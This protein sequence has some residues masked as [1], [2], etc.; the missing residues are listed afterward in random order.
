[1]LNRNGHKRT[2]CVGRAGDKVANRILSMGNQPNSGWGEFSV[3]PK[4]GADGAAPGTCLPPLLL[5]WG[6]PRGSPS[7][8]RRHTEHLQMRSPAPDVLTQRGATW[9]DTGS[10][11][12]SPQSVGP[13]L[14][15]GVT[16]PCPRLSWEERSGETARLRPAQRREKNK[17]ASSKFSLCA[18]SPSPS[19]QQV[20][21]FSWRDSAPQWG[22][23][24]SNPRRLAVCAGSLG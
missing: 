10:L 6:G 5:D 24:A 19:L 21:A 12:G 14:R 1:M 16:H 4:Q 18:R 3:F 13:C 2:R 9:R 8:S 23:R 20:G 17:P 7:G 15:S 11:A 22:V